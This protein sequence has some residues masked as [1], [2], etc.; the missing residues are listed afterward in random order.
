[1][2]V[3]VVDH[4]QGVETVMSGFRFSWSLHYT[5]GKNYNLID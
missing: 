4:F 1:V 5:T 3:G 2:E